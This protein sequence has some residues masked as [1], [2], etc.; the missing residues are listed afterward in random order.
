MQ[1][2]LNEALTPPLSL[3]AATQ[4][5]IPAV[6]GDPSARLAGHGHVAE[7]IGA[8]MLAG[9]EA[10]DPD[11][12]SAQRQTLYVV[13]DAITG[14]RGGVPADMRLH[15]VLH[16]G[17]EVD[18]PLDTASTVGTPPIIL[19][20]H[21]RVLFPTELT[22][23]GALR[24]LSVTIVLDGAASGE[25]RPMATA[26]VPANV[27]CEA[28]QCDLRYGGPP[29]LTEFTTHVITSLKLVLNPTAHYQ[30]FCAAAGVAGGAKRLVLQCRAGWEPLAIGYGTSDMDGVAVAP[31]VDS[32]P[33]TRRRHLQDATGGGLDGRAQS[34]VGSSIKH[35]VATAASELGQPTDS[36][37]LTDKAEPTNALD[38]VE[39]ADFNDSSIPPSRG[40]G[41]VAG[42]LFSLLDVNSDDL[43]GATF[44]MQEMM[45]LA[46]LHTQ[47][48]Q[49]L[50][51]SYEAKLQV[52]QEQAA[53]KATHSLEI[54][55]DPLPE[56]ETVE[57]L[58]EVERIVERVVER[59]ITEVV[60]EQIFVKVPADDGQPRVHHPTPSYGAELPNGVRVKRAD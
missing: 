35:D 36:T 49:M 6:S 41:D 12:P 38:A 28:L 60:T 52:L 56:P 9:Q 3:H 10:A 37:S 34:G 2:E 21:D 50:H 23:R 14:F 8:A 46:L 7:A 45:D 27:F 19:E 51:R 42:E 40:R 20:G 26:T 1:D 16:A 44:T 43:R 17:T 39:S 31:A 29:P 30:R 32:L 58:V 18:A 59:I 55:T 53:S 47:Q 54:Q 22:L 4:A 25:S 24:G 5:E 11:I 33:P 15:L 57:R 13:P 48:M